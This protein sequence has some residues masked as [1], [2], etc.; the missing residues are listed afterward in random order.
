MREL[1]YKRRS[2]GT[3]VQINDCYIWT[4]IQYLDSPT[5]YRE[6]LHARHT[7]VVW[8]GFTIEDE[9]PSCRL[10]TVGTLTFIGF[11]VCIFF[12]LITR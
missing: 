11:L 2:A 9:R 5:D 4:Q 1:P 6:Y 8:D 7:P 12:V 10:E 3:G